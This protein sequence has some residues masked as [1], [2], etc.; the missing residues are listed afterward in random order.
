MR[1]PKDFLLNN[2]GHSGGRGEAMRYPKDFLLHNK[3]A[4]K[5]W[6]IVFNYWKAGPSYL[7]LKGFLHL[8]PQ[9][10][11][12]SRRRDRLNDQDQWR[13]VCQQGRKKCVQGNATKLPF[14][15]S[16]DDSLDAVDEICWHYVTLLLLRQKFHAQESVN[17]CF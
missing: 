15:L 1:C 16:H 7:L 11:M 14:Q 9:G 17:Q 5:L 2:K 8:Y 13:P 4:I 12:N 6:S 10:R 3:G